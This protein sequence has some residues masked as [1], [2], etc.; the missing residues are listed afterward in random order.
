MRWP[1]RPREAI[2]CDRLLMA[3]SPDRHKL[4]LW[5]AGWE[6]GV[7]ALTLGRLNQ[8]LHV[9][10]MLSYLACTLNLKV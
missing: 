4:R 6:R 7:S 5:G 1:Y 9:K 8:R 10:E 3:R 2:C